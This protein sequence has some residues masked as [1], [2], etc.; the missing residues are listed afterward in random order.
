MSCPPKRGCRC[1]GGAPRSWPWRPSP[2]GSLVPVHLPAA[3]RPPADEPPTGARRTP[4]GTG[5]TRRADRHP[6]DPGARRRHAGP[7][8]RR[9]HHRRAPTGVLP[10]LR[11]RAGAVDPPL[12][13]RPRRHPRRQHASVQTGRTPATPLRRFPRGQ[14]RQTR[15]FPGEGSD[16]D[17][18]ELLV[19]A[20][21]GD[22][23]L[24]RIRA[25]EATSAVLLAATR[26]GLATTPLSQ[27]IEVDTTRHAIQWDVLHVPEHPQLL[28][29]VGWPAS[30]AAE[31][32]ATPVETCAPSCCRPDRRR[33]TRPGDL[34]PQDQGRSPRD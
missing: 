4:P 11:R 34:C 12:P 25:G 19:V 9:P 15:R 16:D 10:R 32:P 3:H 30:T 22:D 5:R 27:G 1:R 26:F 2:A 23:V 31:L 33:Q 17:A 20:T 24:D 6:A 29:R 18:A 8:R 7:A 21:S 13:L 14:L 28:I